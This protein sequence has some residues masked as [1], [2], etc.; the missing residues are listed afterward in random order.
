MRM[1]KL[2]FWG[3]LFPALFVVVA[4]VGV[5]PLMSFCQAHPA[6]A[7]TLRAWG[8]LFLAPFIGI[9]VREFAK[10]SRRRTPVSRAP[11]DWVSPPE[12]PP[13]SLRPEA[14]PWFQPEKML[15]LDSPRWNELGGPRRTPAILWQLWQIRSETFWSRMICGELSDQETVGGAGMAAVPHL[16][17]I[18]R[19]CGKTEDVDYHCFQYWGR[20]GMLSP[21]AARCGGRGVGWADNPGRSFRMD[22]SLVQSRRPI[23]FSRMS[24]PDLRG[25]RLPGLWA[26]ILRLPGNGKG[27]LSMI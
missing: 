24:A 8:L 23:R 5:P 11:A 25:S 3:D 17:E 2:S 10:G 6:Y 12:P 21:R 14:T 4:L 16:M 9:M 26:T 15:P 22:V 1:R 20:Q 18:A 13:G 19:L 27:G 7:W